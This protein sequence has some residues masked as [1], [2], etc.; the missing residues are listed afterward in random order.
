MKKK[1]QSKENF[2]IKYIPFKATFNSE[3][4]IKI[5]NDIKRKYSPN[6]KSKLLENEKEKNKTSNI[7][8]NLN[9]SPFSKKI[10]IP[11]SPNKKNIKR[12]SAL[13]SIYNDPRYNLTKISNESEKEIQ[14][15]LLIKNRNREIDH[16]IKERQ[17]LK[18]ILVLTREPHSLRLLSNKIMNINLRINKLIKLNDYLII[19]PDEIERQI[20]MKKKKI[21]R[22]NSF[23]LDDINFSSMKNEMKKIN[24]YLKIN[25]INKDAQ[26]ID[27]ESD[28]D[29]VTN[30]PSYLFQRKN[31]NL[32]F[33]P[34]TEFC[35][36][37]RKFGTSTIY[38]KFF[39][40]IGFTRNKN[41]SEK[42]FFFKKYAKTFEDLYYEIDEKNKNK[43]SLSQR[44][45]N[46]FNNNNSNIIDSFNN[47]KINNIN[48]LKI[49]T[50]DS[51]DLNTLNINSNSSREKS[52]STRPKT[53]NSLFNKKLNIPNLKTL[54]IKNSKKYHKRT[55]S[56]RYTNSNFNKSIYKILNDTQIIKD[57]IKNT[58]K[59]N[60]KAKK[61]SENILL[62][63]EE[64][65]KKKKRK[66]EKKNKVKYY[67]GKTFEEQLLNKL[68]SI[69]KSAKNEFRKAYIQIINEDRILD[70]PDINKLDKYEDQERKIKENKKLREQAKKVMYFL[71]EN[72]FTGREDKEVF[73]EEMIFDNYGNINSLEW[74]I[75]KHSILNNNNKLIG[76]YNT[77]E[78]MNLKIHYPI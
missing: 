11:S 12:E 45:I 34:S 9:K 75:R 8:K 20:K 26:I 40:P 73:K 61:D 63:L 62:K 33:T 57:S 10:P 15:K 38:S 22:N 14:I 53:G 25:K 55:L 70:K 52:C 71:K 18:K 7:I 13:T 78:K 49:K 69:P 31:K 39:K 64:K 32:L 51:D 41:E 44:N 16:L 2:D 17:K 56:E 35:S 1:K 5:N 50:I 65:L 66:N 24:V 36:F 74:L 43:L 23:N 37:K 30:K 59:E 21:K 46:T 42:K 29:N 67:K 27:F 3:K 54:N 76:A 58:I 19:H 4:R 6:P 28:L 77:K 48:K 68:S 72:N 47:S 60:R